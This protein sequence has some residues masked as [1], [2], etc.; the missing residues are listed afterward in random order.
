MSGNAQ[1][2]CH[3]VEALEHHW[4]WAVLL[5]EGSSLYVSHGSV[6]DY[7]LPGRDGGL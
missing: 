3:S 5:S 6:I 1:G 4:Y 7:G 2:P